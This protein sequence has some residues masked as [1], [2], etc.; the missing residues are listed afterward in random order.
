MTN[1][2]LRIRTVFLIAT[3]L[4]TVNAVSAQTITDTD[5]KRNITTINSPLKSLL[6]LEPRVFEYETEK[7][8]SLRL[9]EGRQYGFLADNMQEVFPGMV[10][11]KHVNYMYGKNTYRQAS[12]RTV[13]EV[14]LIPVLV[15]SIQELHLEVEK[16][17]QEL[18]SLKKKDN[19]FSVR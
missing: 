10:N 8:K 12:I 3:T 5:V 17:K 15:A 2:R 4:F 16:L 13:D 7:F 19:S 6:R 9:K 11:S 1:I 18:H 14:S